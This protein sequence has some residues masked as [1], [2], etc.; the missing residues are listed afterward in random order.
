MDR[1]KLI[2]SHKYSLTIQGYSKRNIHFQK[3]I[4][5]VL[6]SIWRSAFFFLDEGRTLKDI[7]TPYKHSMWAPRVTRQC[8][9]DDPALP[10]LVAECHRQK[11]PQ[12]QWC[13]A[14]DHR[15][16]D[17]ERFPF[18][19]Y[20][21]HGFRISSF[22]K[23]NFWKCILLFNNPVLCL[24]Q[25]R[26]QVEKY[27]FSVTIHTLSSK[28]DLRTLRQ[29]RHWYLRIWGI[30]QVTAEKKVTNV[31]WVFPTKSLPARRTAYRSSCKVPVIFLRF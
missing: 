4:L 12:P 5:Q 10:T 21:G 19:L 27:T 1:H 14:S 13:A 20:T 16:Q 18:H 29:W 2:G 22:C 26:R 8:Q 11:Q 25:S 15:Y 31:A 28:F 30:P 23:I 9:I 3:F 7:F 24:L 6:L 17:F